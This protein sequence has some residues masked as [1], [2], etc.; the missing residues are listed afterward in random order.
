MFTQQLGADSRRRGQPGQHGLGIVSDRGEVRRA[1]DVE[2]AESLTGRG[3]DEIDALL[4]DLLG[5][6]PS[7]SRAAKG[8]VDMLTMSAS[9]PA[10]VR[11]A[12]PPPPI[13]IGGCGRCT[14]RG[15][16][17]YPCTRTNSPEQS[18][19]LALPVGLEQGHHLGQLGDS[20]AG[21]IEFDPM[22][23]YSTSLQP[24]PMPI[25]RRPSESRSSVAA[26]LAS[27]AGT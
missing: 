2:T 10:N 12:C 26:S 18:S 21:S 19:S 14:G 8:T 6:K 16:P 27:T 5:V 22:A 23:L 7:A 25:S 24:A 13:M 20:P 15:V 11:T 4:R 3:T 17:A 9:R 1:L